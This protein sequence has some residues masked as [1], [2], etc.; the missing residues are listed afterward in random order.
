LISNTASTMGARVR[1]WPGASS[2]DIPRKKTERDFSRPRKSQLDYGEHIPSSFIMSES[3]AADEMCPYTRTG[4][5]F[6]VR[7]CL[8][9]GLTASAFERA[10]C[11]REFGCRRADRCLR[12]GLWSSTF[13]TKNR[14]GVPPGRLFDFS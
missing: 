7:G 13:H 1:F 10:F 8:V 5:F 2:D 12:G 11:Q 3:P 4:M 6:E 9:A 14:P